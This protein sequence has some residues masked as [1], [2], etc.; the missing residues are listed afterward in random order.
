MYKTTL[1]SELVEKFDVELDGDL[2]LELKACAPLDI[3]QKD[4]VS[5][6]VNPVYRQQATTSQVY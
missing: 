3:A 5:F 4:N 2:S 1:L 6:L